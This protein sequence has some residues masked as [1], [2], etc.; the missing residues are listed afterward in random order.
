MS[1][2]WMRFDQIAR[3]IDDA[4]SVTRI[5]FYVSS[6]GS[7]GRLLEIGCRLPSMR[8]M[9]K[10]QAEEL[11]KQLNAGIKPTLTLHSEGMLSKAANQLRRFL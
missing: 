9:G 1:E 8:Y 2:A 10:G 11:V 5:E 3:V 6:D 4:D 7:N